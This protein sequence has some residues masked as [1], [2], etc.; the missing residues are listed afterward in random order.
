MTRRHNPRHLTTAILT[1]CGLTAALAGG[2]MVHQT[3]ESHPPLGMPGAF[4]ASGEAPLADHWWEAFG[5]PHLTALVDEALAGNFTIRSA[6]DRLDQ[7]RAVAQKAGAPLWPFLDGTA[8]ASRSVTENEGEGTTGG[9]GGFGGT[10]G[11]TVRTY[12]TDVSLG[13]TASYEVDLWGRIRSARDAAILDVAASAEDLRAAAITL[14]AQIAGTWLR[15]G[16]LRGRLAILDDQHATNEQ[17]LELITL[18]FRRGRA[19]ATDVLQQRQLVEATRGERTL[20]QSGIAVLEHQLAILLG[21]A[22]GTANLPEVT[23]V[24]PLPPLPETGLPAD[25]LRRRPDVLASE[26][27][28]RSADARVGAAVAD[29]FPR[30]SLAATVG[31]SAEQVRDLFDNWVATLAANVVAPLFDANLRGAEVHRTRALLSERLN[32]YGQ[33]VLDALA[34]VED[35]LVQEARQAENV[36]SL[37]RQLALA[38][39]ASEQTLANYTKG[40]DDFTRYLTTLLSYQ[41]LEKATLQARRDLALFRVDLYRALAGGWTMDRPPTPALG[42]DTAACPDKPQTG[43]ING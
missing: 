14:S 38:R 10:P 13:L 18:R 35:A 8:G 28:V 11:G 39:Q 4:S 36:A 40:T 23:A 17:V 34:E 12:T 30:L 26:L 22:P 25:L 37:E 7:A 20:V 27:R 6:W 15:M 29:Q 2:C 33:T 41:N 19:G 32:V 1:A 24:P 21:R 5:D 3:G 31:T 16:E 9:R 42:G 43:D